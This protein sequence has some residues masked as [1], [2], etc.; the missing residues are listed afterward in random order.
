[1]VRITVLDMFFIP[2]LGVPLHDYLSKTTV[3]G[4]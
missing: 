2:F 1:L 4:R 3:V